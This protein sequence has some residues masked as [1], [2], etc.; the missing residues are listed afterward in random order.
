M[1]KH[2]HKELEKLKKKILSLGAMVEDRVRMAIKA[3]DL[4]FNHPISDYFLE[5]S[6]NEAF[7]KN[8]VNVI[9]VDFRALD[10]M[11]EVIVLTIAAVGAAMLF[12]IKKRRA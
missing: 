4:E 7:G 3:I 2:F 10:T 5:K 6:Y 11:G 8:V 12:K 1:A 9:L